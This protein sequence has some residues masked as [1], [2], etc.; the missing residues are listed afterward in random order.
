MRSIDEMG[1][2]FYKFALTLLHV[3]HRKQLRA[4]IHASFV[5]NVVNVLLDGGNAH[6]NL[7]A[8][9]I[10]GATIR[11][12]TQNISF[13]F[14]KRKVGNCLLKV[15]FACILY[16]VLVHQILNHV[17]NSFQLKQYIVDSL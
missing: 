10:I 14:R 13:S 7:L 5:E 11:N 1:R 9:L 3:N 4:G 16:A 8:Y 15:N 17:F 12:E 2:F 6:M